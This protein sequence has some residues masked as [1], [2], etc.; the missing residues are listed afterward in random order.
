MTLR[1]LE[2]ECIR[3][4]AEDAET[5]L[6]A[7]TYYSFKNKDV[8]KDYFNNVLSSINR[9][10]QKVST[11][12]K[13]PYITFELEVTRD[14]IS[15][16]TKDYLLEI[17]NSQLGK[18]LDIKSIYSVSLFFKGEYRPIRFSYKNN[19][20]TLKNTFFRNTKIYINFVP[21]IKTFTGLDEQDVTIENYERLDTSVNLEDYGIEDEVLFNVV[22]NFVKS[23]LFAFDNPTL[24]QRYISL[25][26]TYLSAMDISESI[27]VDQDYVNDENCIVGF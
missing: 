26:E 3:Y 10:L 17:C 2:V 4:T 24:A 15:N 1:E 21:K 25:G 27:L 9:A 20:L 14:N 13:I 23:D 19:K 5:G 6:T 12:D 18:N 7:E 22:L 11:R 16:L 8:Y